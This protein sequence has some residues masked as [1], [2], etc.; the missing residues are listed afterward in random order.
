M[1]HSFLVTLVVILIA[2]FLVVPRVASAEDQELAKLRL[3]LGGTGY[4]DTLSF[5]VDGEYF[6]TPQISFSAGFLSHGKGTFKIPAP[7]S[8]PTPVSHGKYQF[9]PLVINYYAHR[10]EKSAFSIGVGAYLGH[11]E[12]PPAEGP[13]KKES[14]TGFGLKLSGQHYLSKQFFVEATTEMVSAFDATLWGAGF[15]LGYDF[16]L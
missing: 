1:K 2:G 3:K 11:I 14:E 12:S 16:S 9:I 6:I 15:M 7:K 5:R 13:I 10:T 8:S 4:L